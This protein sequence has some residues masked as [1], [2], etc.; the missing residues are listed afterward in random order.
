MSTLTDEQRAALQ[1]QLMAMRLALTQ[2]SD[3][4]V[5]DTRPVS[6]DQPIGRLTRM[7]AMQQQ[8]MA[9]GQQQRI[10]QE[11]QQ[12]E[13]ALQR[14]DDNRYGYCLRCKDDIPYDRLRV[15]PTTTLCVHCQGDLETGRDKR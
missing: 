9:I 15:R 4:A 2:R 1:Q 6:L 14:L 13:A 12:I 10:G 5:E 3:A 7:D 11:L 8:Q